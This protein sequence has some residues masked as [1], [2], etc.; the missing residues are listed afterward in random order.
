MLASQFLKGFV[1]ELDAKVSIKNKVS[2]D[3]WY[4]A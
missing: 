4:S 2:G 3:K 1:V